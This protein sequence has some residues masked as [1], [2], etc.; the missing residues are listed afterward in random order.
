MFGARSKLDIG[1][2]TGVEQATCHG[3]QGFHPRLGAE[4]AVHA[5]AGDG[6]PEVALHSRRAGGRRQVLR[7]PGEAGEQPTEA[8]V[9]AKPEAAKA[10]PPKVKKPKVKAMAARK[11]VA[12]RT[13]KAA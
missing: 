4:A 11:S 2:L 8:K 12:V 6:T 10:E 9:E 7:G 13:R 3:R 5:G 1:C